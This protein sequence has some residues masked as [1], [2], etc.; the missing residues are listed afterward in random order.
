[1]QSV[2]KEM[3]SINRTKRDRFWIRSMEFG[4]KYC[5]CHQMPER[6]FFLGDYQFPVCARCTGIGAGHLLGAV[7]SLRIDLP[8]K[9][10]L[11]ALPLA[12]D[13]TVQYLTDYESNN[14]RRFLTGV[15]Y[16]FAV[17]S[18]IFHTGRLLGKRILSVKRA[19]FSD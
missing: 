18:A 14:K 10:L 3:E 17:M 12:A 19:G 9:V 2:W 11:A 15:L 6:S 4:R 1:M 8:Y 5:G 13:G 7:V 16:G